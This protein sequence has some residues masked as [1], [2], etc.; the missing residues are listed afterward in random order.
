V[1]VRFSQ[2]GRMSGDIVKEFVVES[3]EN[4]DLLDRELIKLE[5][6]PDNRETLASIFR[7]IHTIKGTKMH[8]KLPRRSAR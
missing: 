8:T 3:G 1:E 6:D 2:G 5:T 4:L 7:R